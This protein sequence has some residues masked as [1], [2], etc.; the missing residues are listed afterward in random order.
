M[1]MLARPEAG[2]P[3]DRSTD[4]AQCGRLA[5]MAACGALGWH[6]SLVLDDYAD[7]QMIA[8]AVAAQTPEDIRASDTYEDVL[9]AID[10][11]IVRGCYC[12]VGVN[13]NGFCVPTTWVTG[14][15]HWLTCYSDGSPQD[16]YNCWAATYETANLGTCHNA[17]MGTVW[18]WKEAATP[19]TPEPTP[20]HPQP[21]PE[22]PGPPAPQSVEDDDMAVLYQVTLGVPEG[23]G[24]GVWVAHGSSYVHVDQPSFQSYVAAG[25]KPIAIDLAQHEAFLAGLGRDP[26]PEPPQVSASESGA[27]T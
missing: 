14:I 22:P 15:T 21:E 16:V 23:E 4:H 24:P 20:P 6:G 13:C 3:E 2:E 27:A 10:A 9:A 17:E 1:T 5:A 8:G 26:A 18:I 19:P 11:G 12:I 7:A 25:Y